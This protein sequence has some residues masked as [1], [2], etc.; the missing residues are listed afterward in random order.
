[1]D[2]MIK[3]RE[4]GSDQ[5]KDLEGL[6][7]VSPPE[8]HHL[9]TAHFQGSKIA[10]KQ[11]S[12]FSYLPK[13]SFYIREGWVYENRWVVLQ[14]TLHVFGCTACSETMLQTIIEWG[15]RG[16]QRAHFHF[17][18]PLEGHT[19]C[20]CNLRLTLHCT[21]TVHLHQIRSQR[22]LPTNLLIGPTWSLGLFPYSHF[23]H[24][25]TSQFY[26]S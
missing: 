25:N 6:S 4:K 9:E 11:R 21:L 7:S 3:I 1:M 13:N 18:L 17:F 26:L 12:C 2:D 15:I 10:K 5:R 19:F 23:L 24:S 16:P 14:C 22:G 20:L 8:P